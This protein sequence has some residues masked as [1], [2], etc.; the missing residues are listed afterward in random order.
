[1]LSFYKLINFTNYFYLL[2]HLLIHFIKIK[3]N[4]WIITSLNSIETKDLNDFN[5]NGAFKNFLWIVI[6]WNLGNIVLNFFNRYTNFKIKTFISEKI[7]K[8]FYL[9]S[10]ENKETHSLQLFENSLVIDKIYERLLFTIPKILIYVFYY[11]YLLFSFSYQLL[12]ITIVFNLVGVYITRKFNQIKKNIFNKIYNIEV[13]L[14]NEHIK[15]IKDNT[16]HDLENLYKLRNKEKENEAYYLHFSSI[17]TEL[18]TDILLGLIYCIGFSYLNPSSIN[19]IK[20]I[21]L[22][23]MGI[24]SSNF[25]NF[26]I[27][28][29]DCYHNHSQD[30]IQLGNL[31]KYFTN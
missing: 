19:N 9:K 16:E 15:Y 29:I 10:I 1:M 22:M 3:T 24:N 26:I 27:D 11:T 21:E 7:S 25:L 30:L 28:L 12:F 8:Y 5:I 17:S 2:I 18:F 14:K 31:K 20:P 6:F 4:R 23:Y 13:N